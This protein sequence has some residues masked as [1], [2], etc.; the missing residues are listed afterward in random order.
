MIQTGKITRHTLVWTTDQSEWVEASITALDALPDK[1]LIAEELEQ[2]GYVCAIGSVGKMN[3]MDLSKLDPEN[4]EQLADA[5]DISPAMVKEIEFIN[6][7]ELVEI[8]PVSIRMRKRI[9]AA[10]MRPKPPR[11]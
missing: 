1:A 5:F 9:L 3:G 7:D 11:G 10:N 6:D 8:T 2:D 4:H